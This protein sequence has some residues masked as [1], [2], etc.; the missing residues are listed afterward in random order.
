MM[1]R[2]GDTGCRYGGERCQFKNREVVKF[3]SMSALAIITAMLVTTILLIFCVVVKQRA[4]IRKLGY[5]DTVYTDET[6]D[7]EVR[8]P[9][10]VT[11]HPLP[12]W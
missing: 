8:Q 11:T 6:G 7:I 5:Y 1:T 3:G 2:F 10:T 4:R 9:S 12:L